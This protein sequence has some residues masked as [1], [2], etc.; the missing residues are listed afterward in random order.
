MQAVIED[1]GVG[2]AVQYTGPERRTRERFGLRIMRERVNEMGGALSIES[3]AGKGT[4]VIVRLPRNLSAGV[5]SHLR[6]VIVDDHPL[7]TDGLRN[8]LAV[9]R[10]AGDG[11]GEGRPRGAGSGTRLE[12]RPDPDG[13]QH[14]A[15]ERSGGDAPHQG[16]HARS[17]DR[18]VDHLCQ[19]GGSLRSPAH[20]RGGLPA[21]GDERERI[22]HHPYRRG[23][24]RGG[25]FGGDGTGN[26]RRVSICR[27]NAGGK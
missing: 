23:T 1:K 19:R 11:R 14:A 26:S 24:R 8:M 20:R 17:E 18:D 9:A 6:V 5:L 12:A 2:M 16:G 25:V 22:V 3:E 7:F 15:H 13:Y 4:R 27:W 10:H 21:Q